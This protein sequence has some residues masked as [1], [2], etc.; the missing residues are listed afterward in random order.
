MTRLLALVVSRMRP[1]TIFHP[2]IEL[3]KLGAIPVLFR[4][5]ARNAYA[6][7]NW[8]GRNEC[9]R[10][11]VDILNIMCLS[12]SLAEEIVAVDVYTYPGGAA[13]STISSLLAAQRSPRHRG[14]V[15]GLIL[16]DLEDTDGGEDND[17]GVGGE[18]S[19]EPR[20]VVAGPPPANVLRRGTSE[21]PNNRATQQQ[22]PPRSARRNTNSAATP[23]RTLP[24]LTPAG[25]GGAATPTGGG[26]IDHLADEPSSDERINGLL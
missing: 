17:D 6:H 15:T 8:P 3:A 22:P 10:V 9:T 11:A 16:D 4:V 2:I 20:L 5:I 1:D 14:R 21:L 25:G 26:D 24:T 13:F 12:T 19:D 7:S 23:R 18:D